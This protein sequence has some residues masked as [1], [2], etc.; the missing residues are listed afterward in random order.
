[1]DFLSYLARDPTFLTRIYLS[2]E[3]NFKCDCTHD[4]LHFIYCFLLVHIRY[5][6]GT[7]WFDLPCPRRIHLRAH[8]AS[9][10]LQY[11]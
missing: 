1:M 11:S 9:H 5:Y 4:L 3:Y 10:L 8:P 2:R 7:A 6:L